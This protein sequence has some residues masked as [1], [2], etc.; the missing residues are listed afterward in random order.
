MKRSVLILVLLFAMTARAQEFTMN[1]YTMYLVENPFTISPA[2]AGIDE[3]IHVFVFPG[4]F[5][6]QVW[7]MHPIRRH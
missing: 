1:P 3:D 2:Y 5:S 7:K 4:H 6:G